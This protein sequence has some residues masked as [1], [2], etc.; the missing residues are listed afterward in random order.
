LEIKRKHIVNPDFFNRNTMTGSPFEC[1]PDL[2]HVVK[3]DFCVSPNL[4]HIVNPDFFDSNA[5]VSS[6][7]ASTSTQRKAMSPP[8]P[9]HF[10][11]E[12][13][14]TRRA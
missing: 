12:E 3:P 14:G 10:S 7:V 9:G 8:E 1:F 6:S 4:K 5:T 2:K 13:V 11:V